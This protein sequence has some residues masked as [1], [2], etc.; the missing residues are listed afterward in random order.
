MIDWNQID[1]VLFDMDGTLLDLQFDNQV[2]SRLLPKQFAS[3]HGLTFEDANI[4][5]TTHMQEIFGRIEFYCLNY[6]A[7]YTGLDVMASHREAVHLIR[8]RPNALALARSL[9]TCGKRIVLVTNAHRDSLGIKQSHCGIID[10]MDAVVSAHD[11]AAPKEASEFWQR[12]NQQHPFDPKRT[13]FIDDNAHVLKSARAYGIAY[14]LTIAQPDSSR[15]SRL[16]LE[17]PAIDDFLSHFPVNSH[18]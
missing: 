16:G 7:R 2:W 1:T 11:Y 9:R 12:L 4:Q 13:L 10:E 3:A 17:H 18:V 5:L 14:A 15:P 6:W 8:W